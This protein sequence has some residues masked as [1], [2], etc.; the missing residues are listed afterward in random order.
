[1]VHD[2]YLTNPSSYRMTYLNS[3]FPAY[4]LFLVSNL[5]FISCFEF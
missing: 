2:N 5:F 3:L 4:F 1:M